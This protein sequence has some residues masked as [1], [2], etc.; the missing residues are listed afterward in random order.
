MNMKLLFTF[1]TAMFLVGNIFAQDA[2][3][4]GHSSKTLKDWAASQINSEEFLK[5]QSGIRSILSNTEVLHTSEV[6]VISGSSEVSIGTI[7]DVF[8][9]FDSAKAASKEVCLTFGIVYQP[10]KVIISDELANLVSFRK[11][12]VIPA[13]LGDQ[14][15]VVVRTDVTA[16]DALDCLISYL[17]EGIGSKSF[18]KLADPVEENSDDDFRLT[19]N[20]VYFDKD[21]VQHIEPA[22]NPTA[23]TSGS[24]KT[25]R[26]KGGSSDYIWYLD[27]NYGSAIT[28]TGETITYRASSESRAGVDVL[29]LNDGF[30]EVSISISSGFFRAEA[31]GSGSKGNKS[32]GCFIRSKSRD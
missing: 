22:S 9:Y 10:C 26:A 24:V 21:L 17:Y 31:D 3:V 1:F 13:S 23:V 6:A 2:S 18:K 30:E 5:L 15:L 7:A 32:G 14:I 4:E 20:I 25:F 19:I 29:Y 11:S 27:T 8:T 12:G 28:G 16:T